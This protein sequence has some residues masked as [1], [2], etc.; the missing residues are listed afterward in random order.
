MVIVFS[1][2]I[3]SSEPDPTPS[4]DEVLARVAIL[5]KD[6]A[7]LTEREAART[8]VVFDDSALI[9]KVVHACLKS[10]SISEDEELL[11]L[12]RLLQ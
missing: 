1:T 8:T 12:K 10:A 7:T 6:V 2:I 3:V 9:Y 5:E 4:L 11:I